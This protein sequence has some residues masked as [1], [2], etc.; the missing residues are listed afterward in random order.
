MPASLSQLHFKG[1][2][3]DAREARVAAARKT[4]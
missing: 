1:D 4:A 3:R 2:C